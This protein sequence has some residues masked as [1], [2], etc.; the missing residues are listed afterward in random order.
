MLPRLIG[1]A[2]ALDMLFSA[3]LVDASEALRMGLVNP[4]FRSRFL[5]AS[6]ATQGAGATMS[7]P[8]PC[9]S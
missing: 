6:R 3:R 8:D 4:F 9:A 5:E 2:N 1:P 7:A